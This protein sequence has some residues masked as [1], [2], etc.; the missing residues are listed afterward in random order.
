MVNT[1]LIAKHIDLL[2]C[3][4]SER[5]VCKICGKQTTRYFAEKKI[6]SEKFNDFDCCKQIKSDIVCVLCASCIKNATL[7]RSCFY[8]DENKLVYFKKD[9]IEKIVFNMSKLVQVPFVFCFT[10]SFKKHNSFK[11]QPNYST[12]CFSIQFENERFLFDTKK[13]SELYYNVLKPAYFELLLSKEEL[14]TGNYTSLV[15]PKKL[16]E[17]EAKL[18]AH[19]GTSVFEFLVFI[20]NSNERNEI[21]KKRKEELKNA[22]KSKKTTRG[23]VG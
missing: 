18:K 1:E 16:F 22:R 12:S 2:E 8:A 23:N 20:L 13:C 7:R 5:K 4:E 21:L 19:R 15:E 10:Q 6:L 3:E 14:L 17:L 9:D 11:A